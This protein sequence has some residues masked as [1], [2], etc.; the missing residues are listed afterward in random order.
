MDFRRE[1]AEHDGEGLRVFAVFFMSNAGF[2]FLARLTAFFGS[3]SPSGS[4]ARQIGFGCGVFLL[5]V[6]CGGPLRGA[7][8]QEAPRLSPIKAAR[9]ELV[10]PQLNG[11]EQCFNAWDDNQNG[12]IDEGCGIGQAPVQVFVAWE[13]E[14]TDLD[15]L[16]FDPQGELATDEAPT[17][18]GMSLHR[19][20]PVTYECGAQPFEMAYSEDD[21]YRGGHYRVMVLAR[22]FDRELGQ[23]TAHLGVQTPEGTYSYRLEF[24]DQGQSTEVDFFVAAH[25]QKE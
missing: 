21:S 14:N 8:K 19:D 3:M 25:P 15:L 5:L 7:A 24:F 17:A 13:D 1:L 23:I 9:F 16:V 2:V 20:C 11:W 6:G 22:K 12:L 18:S 10:Q 4:V